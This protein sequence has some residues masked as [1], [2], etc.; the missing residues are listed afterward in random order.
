MFLV[1]FDINESAGDITELPKSFVLIVMTVSV[2]FPSV[3]LSPVNARAHVKL[4]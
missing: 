1:I 4:M 2:L 3:I